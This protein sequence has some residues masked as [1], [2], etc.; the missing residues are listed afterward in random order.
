MCALDDVPSYCNSHHNQPVSLNPMVDVSEWQR[1]LEAVG[2]SEERCRT[3]ADL[4]PVVVW[5][6]DVDCDIRS[7]SSSGTTVE[8]R[9]PTSTIGL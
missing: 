1:A 4:A 8:I 2:E 6:T 9:V 7:T 3:L 5:M